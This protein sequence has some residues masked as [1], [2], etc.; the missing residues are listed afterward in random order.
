MSNVKATIEDVK[1]EIEDA[2]ENVKYPGD[3]HL[4]HPRSYDSSEV[5]D[6]Q[7]KHWKSWKELPREIINSN[8]STLCFLSPEAYPF[9]LPAYMIYG[10]E[11]PPDSNVLMFT[12]Y[13]LT[14]PAPSLHSIRSIP[15]RSAL[16]LRKPLPLLT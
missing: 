4:L 3:E 1:K 12:V 8:H 10:L 7:G 13:N 16:R 2:F 14:A 11:D 15:S 9:F 6:F 5:E